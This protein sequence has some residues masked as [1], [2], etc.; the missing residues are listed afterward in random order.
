MHL[1]PHSLFL[2][3]LVHAQPAQEQLQ[4]RATGSL[5]SWLASESPV[6]LQGILNNI[7]ASGSLVSGASPGIVVASPSTANP[8]YFYTW[9]YV[10]MTTSYSTI[11]IACNI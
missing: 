8:D 9:T 6:A 2:I 1:L 11:L 4:A 7:G 5:T 10:L 3:S